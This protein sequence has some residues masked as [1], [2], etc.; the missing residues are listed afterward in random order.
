MNHSTASAH[1]SLQLRHLLASLADDT[2]LTAREVSMILSPDHPSV[3]YIY[4][5]RAKG[6]LRAVRRGTRSLR[7][8]VADVRAYLA[9]CSAA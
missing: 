5:L 3:I 6:L 7:S 8:R 1:E 9:S 2:L 4:Q